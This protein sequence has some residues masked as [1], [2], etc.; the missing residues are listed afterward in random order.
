M[1]DLSYQHKPLLPSQ[2]AV[3]EICRM[4]GGQ[5]VLAERMKVTPSTVSYWASGK[6]PVPV[7]RCI[8]LEQLSGGCYK[9]HQLRPDIF[10]APAA[11]KTPI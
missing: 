7:Q 3:R 8:E 6:Y 11:D 2:Q 5:R 9:R 10:Q 4:L 1:T